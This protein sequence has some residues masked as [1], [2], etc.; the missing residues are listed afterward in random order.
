MSKGLWKV[1][2]ELILGTSIWEYEV[3]RCGDWRPLELYVSC[4]HRNFI[5]NKVTIVKTIENFLPRQV[6]PENQLP[7]E[8]F[9]NPCSCEIFQSWVGVHLFEWTSSVW[10]IQDDGELNKWTPGIFL[11]FEKTVGSKSMV[12]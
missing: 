3:L 4:F 12:S 11:K 5:W 8:F 6:K 7:M 1:I 9:L 2:S 10:S